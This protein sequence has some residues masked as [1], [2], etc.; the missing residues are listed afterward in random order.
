MPDEQQG[1]AEAGA[2]TPAEQPANAPANSAAPEG[3]AQQE[4]HP[5]APA[6]GETAEERFVRLQREQLAP[7]G[8]D[9]HRMLSEAKAG[10]SVSQLAARYGVST[11][12]F[13]QWLDTSLDEQAGSSG[14]QGGD[15]PGG[16]AIGDDGQVLTLGAYKQLMAQ[17][18]QQAERASQQEQY[19]QRRQQAYSERATA[20][21]DALAE[22]GYKPDAN[23][24]LPDGANLFRDLYQ[25][26]LDDVIADAVPLHEQ[27]RLTQILDVTVPTPQQR[28]EAKRRMVEAVKD[29]QT[30]AISSF[31]AGQQNAP[32]Q[33]LEGGHGGRAGQPEAGAQNM[34][35]RER[36]GMFRTW[37]R[38]STAA[39]G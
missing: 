10:S 3:Q 27:R 2:S 30:R 12:A 24:N 31:A 20:A 35:P 1:P 32:S 21:Q 13:L 8:G 38:E 19:N 29:M 14:Q 11:D 23:G 17:Q 4:Q 9:T 5:G 16:E 7:W 37:A 26:V 34:N 36:R 15:E 25:T 33:S 39:R 22:I 18:Q 28:A 6:G